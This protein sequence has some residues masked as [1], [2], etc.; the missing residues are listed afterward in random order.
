MKP[1]RPRAGLPATIRDRL[2]RLPR[3]G[4]PATV[5]SR[6]PTTIRGRRLAALAILVAF[7]GG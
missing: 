5:R 7:V 3:P 2:K 4:L 1:R 6:L